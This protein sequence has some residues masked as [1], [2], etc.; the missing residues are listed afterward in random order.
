MAKKQLSASRTELKAVLTLQAVRLYDAMC[1]GRSWP[2]SDWLTFIAGHPLMGQ[3]AARLV[4]AEAGDGGTRAF[5]PTEDGE[6]I[7]ADDQLVV[8]PDTAQVRLAHRVEL[9]DAEAERWA[10]HLRDYEVDA[11]FDQFGASTPA[12]PEDA[13]ALDDL[14]GHVTDTFAFRGVA[15][16]RGYRRGGA[17][18]G[19]WFTEYTKE[20][21]GAG[22]VAVIE[23]TGSFLPEDS[24]PCATESL[25]F[26]RGHHQVPL[27][28][29][30][31]VLRAECYADYAALAA[32][33]PFDPNYWD[34]VGV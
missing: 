4:W 23:F 34:K 10:G 24:M 17:E 11:L 14:K 29:V 15:T 26:R 12:Y 21:A 5:R 27:R 2:A 32:L 8:L 16:K 25:S 22:L 30:P 19:G 28:E 13:L 33:G 3:L 9:G 7:D 18:D 6:L 1:S 31:P 20:F